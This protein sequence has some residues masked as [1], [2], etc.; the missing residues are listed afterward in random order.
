MAK[1]R[2][3]RSYLWRYQLR[4]WLRRLRRDIHEY[5]T[6]P[7]W[8]WKFRKLIRPG[9]PFYEAVKKDLHENLMAEEDKQIL[10]GDGTPHFLEGTDWSKIYIEPNTIEEVTDAGSDSGQREDG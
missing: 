7:V 8:R 5:L 3:L 2:K 9:N 10:H 4:K 1:P 6:H